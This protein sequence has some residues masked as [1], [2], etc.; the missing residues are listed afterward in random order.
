MLRGIQL[1]IHACRASGLVH[2]T[3]MLT[4]DH[5]A[6]FVVRSKPRKEQLAVDGLARRG[7]TGYCPWILEP[8]GWTN[9]WATVPLFPGYLFVEIRLE[10]S[11]HT[12]LWTPGVKNF[13]AFGSVPV[14][15]QP[16]VVRFLQDEGGEDGVIRPVSKLRSGQRV[17]IRRGPFA[18]LVG[19]IERPCP[20]RGRIRVLM[21]FLR[22]GTVVDVPIAAVGRI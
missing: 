19:I 16:D 7:V 12:V 13:V 22:Q 6:W 14:P 4:Q 21:D 15:V 3:Y 9:E 17:R 18:G 11:Y 2:R 1:A 20:E 5:V 10:D 8:V